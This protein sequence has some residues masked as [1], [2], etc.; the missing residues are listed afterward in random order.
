[1]KYLASILVILALIRWAAAAHVTMSA[2]PAQVTM[3]VL[4]L[5]VTLAVCLMLAAF[6]FIGGLVWQEAHSG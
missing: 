1:M 3:P 2:G 6:A 5:V 4:A